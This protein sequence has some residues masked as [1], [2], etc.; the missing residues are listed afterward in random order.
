MIAILSSFFIVIAFA[1]GSP[2]GRSLADVQV[3][4]NIVE[5][6]VYICFRVAPPK[7]RVTEP[8]N[9]EERV[10]Q[11]TPE[12]NSKTEEKKNDRTIV[13]KQKPL[14]RFAPSEK[15]KADQAVDFPQ[16]I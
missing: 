1:T 14:K 16:D 5:E 6:K 8:D 7:N 3:A 4:H 15:I 13:P 2:P 10:R 12:A 11:K 9:Q